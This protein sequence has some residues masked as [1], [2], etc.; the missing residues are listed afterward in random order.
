MTKKKADESN[1]VAFRESVP[2][3][4]EYKLPRTVGK[5]EV[6]LGFGVYA[7]LTPRQPK[8]YPLISLRVL[9][10]EYESNDFELLLDQRTFD[11]LKE[12]AEQY[13]GKDNG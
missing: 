2:P 13:W 3:S 8:E 1:I 6:Y 5:D 4:V 11:R 12:F 9:K 7:R 10:P